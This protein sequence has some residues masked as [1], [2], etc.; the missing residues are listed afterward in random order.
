[1]P[2]S[3]K[4]QKEPNRIDKK[5]SDR[6]YREKHRLCGIFIR[7][8][9]NAVVEKRLPCLLKNTTGSKRLR[10]R[11]DCYASKGRRRIIAEV[12]GY[13]GHKTTMAH[14]AAKFRLQCIRERYGKNIE[15]YRFTLKRLS[16]WTD[17]EIAQEMRL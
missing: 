16:K 3:K 4:K 9:W 6:H 12:D 8:G 7:C 2:I 1:M 17:E 10:Y 5:E 13:K 15:E 11:A 14:N